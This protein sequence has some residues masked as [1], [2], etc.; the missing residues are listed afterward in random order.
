MSGVEADAGGAA[1]PE[2]LPVRIGYSFV[3]TA[4]LQLSISH[5][6]WCSETGAPSNERLEFLGDSVLGLA[7]TNFIYRRYPD[8][9]E[10]DLA[11][12]RAS[13]VNAQTLADAAAE[14][15][16]GADML[17]GKGEE[18][19]G[20]RAKVSIL[21]DA[22]EAVIGAVYLD[23]GWVPAEALV[24]R[25][26]SG[27]IVEYADGPGGGDYKT[28]LQELAA[29]RFDQLPSYRV[30]GAG[31]DHAKTFDAEVIMLGSVRGTGTGRSK[32]QAEQAAA[33]I[34]WQSLTADLESS[35]GDSTPPTLVV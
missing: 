3:D 12:L 11:K 18:S 35:N 34:A 29:H 33:K 13:V 17:L 5:R 31:P 9:P 2:P 20:G 30:V 1:T 10:G 8:L 27:R 32:K 21:A 7:V 4:L 6:S 16:L 23:G 22:L 28:R 15:D 26:L 24:L 19:T 25:L 14:V